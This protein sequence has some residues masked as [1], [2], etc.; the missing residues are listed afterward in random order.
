MV[1]PSRAPPGLDA[2][3]YGPTPPLACAVS[4]THCPASQELRGDDGD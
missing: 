4:V 2:Y 1:P 3:A